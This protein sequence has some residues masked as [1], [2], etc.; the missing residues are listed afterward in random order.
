MSL[1]TFD[2]YEKLTIPVKIKSNISYDVVHKEF[3]TYNECKEYL[4]TVYNGHGDIIS[5][6]NNSIVST[7]AQLHSDLVKVYCSDPRLIYDIYGLIG[8]SY[9]NRKQSN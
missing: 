6:F 9:V 3:P 4:D 5:S 8:E 7:H 2:T 1:N